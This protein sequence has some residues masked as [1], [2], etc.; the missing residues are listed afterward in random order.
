MWG[1]QDPNRAFRGTR[2]RAFPGSGL[3]GL[4][5]S[6]RCRGGF[7]EKTKW[8]GSDSAGL[9][10]TVVVLG[11]GTAGWMTASYLKRAFPSLKITVL[12]SPAIPKIGVGEATI[13][14]LQKVF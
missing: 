5:R 9:I 8:S 14:N 4:G 6:W 11:G 1:S 3:L 12:E 13:P 10:E 7:M 2:I